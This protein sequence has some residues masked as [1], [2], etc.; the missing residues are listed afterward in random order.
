[1][2]LVHEK[3]EFVMCVP[4]V[5]MLCWQPAF[6]LLVCQ[7]SLGYSWAC[8]LTGY[9]NT[10]GQSREIVLEIAQH[11]KSEMFTLWVF[12]QTFSDT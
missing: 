12:A 10:E 7:V 3:T 5:R 11:A 6:L 4:R 8:T 1:M 2:V 9:P